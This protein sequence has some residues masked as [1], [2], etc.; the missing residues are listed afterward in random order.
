MAE[1]A[2]SGLS[3]WK[4]SLDGDDTGRVGQR[5][6]VGGEGWWLGQGLFGLLEAEGV[7][8]N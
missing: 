6:V 8:D 5:R 3:D 4:C 7:D 2:V 1:V